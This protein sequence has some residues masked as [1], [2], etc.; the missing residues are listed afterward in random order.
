MAPDDFRPI[1][2]VHYRLPGAPKPPFPALADSLFLTGVI[3]GMAQWIFG[4]GSIVSVTISDARHLHDLPAEDMARACW[5]D[6]CRALSLPAAEESPGNEP[7]LPPWRLIRERRATFACTTAQLARRPPVRSGLSNLF[8]AG[9][10]VDTGLPAT[11]EGAARS[12]EK[13]AALAL[14]LKASP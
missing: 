2:N 5:R 6:V 9:D 12:G 1:V 13:A 14:A 7:P 8:L 10:W 11:L 3:G 4:R